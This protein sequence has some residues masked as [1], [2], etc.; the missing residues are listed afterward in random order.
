MSEEK[1]KFKR[2]QKNLSSQ[3]FTLMDEPIIDCVIVDL[4]E[5]GARLSVADLPEVVPDYF[6]L[7]LGSVLSK[8]RVRW[9]KG[10]EFGVEFYR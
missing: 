9:R 10:N 5:G 2:V 1:R 7:K 6:K 3:I 4:S 8:C